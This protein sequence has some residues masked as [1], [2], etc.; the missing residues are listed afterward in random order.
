MPAILRLACVCLWL[1]ATP[2]WA[3]PVVHD[4]TLIAEIE[5]HPD[6]VVIRYYI[7]RADSSRVQ[8]RGTPQLER[9]IGQRVRVTTSQPPALAVGELAVEK[10]EA[11]P[12]LPQLPRSRGEQRI[13]VM[14]VVFTN[15]GYPWDRSYLVTTMAQVDAYWREGSFG[16]AWA[17]A[18]VTS[19]LSIALT[20]AN[21]NYWSIGPMAKAAATAA[22]YAL[23][24]Y[25]RYVYAFAGIGCYWYGMAEVGSWPSQVWIHN[26]TAF[27]TFAH[28]LGHNLGLMHAHSATCF[29]RGPVCVNRADIYHSEYGD[30]FDVMGAGQGQHNAYKKARL[31]WL[32]APG[33]PIVQE[34]TGPGVYT[35]DAYATPAVANPKALKF[36][37]GPAGTFGNEEAWIYF[38][39]RTAVGFDAFLSKPIY[40]QIPSGFLV[41]RGDEPQGIGQN[42]L[43]DMTPGS[44][45]STSQDFDDA[46][47][48]V[49]RSWTHEAS[50]LVFTTQAVTGMQATLLVSGGPATVPATP[51]GLTVAGSNHPGG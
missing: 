49:G 47:L 22:G 35:V 30:T 14:P 3:Q 32:N 39:Y 16:Q 44:L 40:A 36:K 13:L 50:G 26:T 21:C 38:E 20:A 7:E 48:A 9:H 5:D 12:L 18:T 43:F 37:Y 15:V 23:S 34:I 42:Y 24:N 1:A 31:A 10:I 4:G 51:S 33:V 2:A 28:E 29:Q 19:P 41:H 45:P 8:V 46:A 6:K 11:L 25:D 27:A 17:T